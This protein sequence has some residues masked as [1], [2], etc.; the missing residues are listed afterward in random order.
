[1]FLRWGGVFEQLVKCVKWCLRKKIGQ[2]KLTQDELLTSLAEVEMVLNSRP[3]IVVSAG[4]L[5]EPLTPSH[6]IMGRRVL[7]STAP[8][9][10]P[11]EFQPVTADD[12]TR[13]TRYLNATIDHFWR[14]WK[15]Y[16]VELVVVRPQTMH[17]RT[18]N[19]TVGCSSYLQSIDM[20]IL[21]TAMSLHAEDPA[22]NSD[23]FYYH[24]YQLVLHQFGWD[25]H[26][27]VNVSNALQV[28]YLVD[29]V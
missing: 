11:D 26:R 15:E 9:P 12:L 5:E 25:L 3:L 23:C 27:D 22:F 18:I 16:L 4:D 6:V 21:R 1:M 10:E 7:S 13:R 24:C 2:A 29:N 19:P 17:A 28:Q 14:K 8:C 20:A